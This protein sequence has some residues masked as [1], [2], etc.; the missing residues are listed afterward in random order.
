ML[1]GESVSDTVRKEGAEQEDSLGIVHLFI[2]SAVHY[3]RIRTREPLAACTFDIQ[4]DSSHPVWFILSHCIFHRT[5]FLS[6]RA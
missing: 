4:I 2:I 6:A 3:R 1:R 5:S